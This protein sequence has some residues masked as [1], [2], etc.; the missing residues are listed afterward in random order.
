MQYQ[1]DLTTGE[2]QWQTTIPIEVKK[3]QFINENVETTIIKD[4]YVVV[5]DAFKQ[6]WYVLLYVVSMLAL[7]FHLVHGFS[8]AF[9]TL[10]VN[11]SKYNGLIKFIGIWVFAIII[12]LLF[13]AMPVYFYFIQ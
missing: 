8:S 12:P 2:L 13:A 6:W 10:G 11:H 4:L 9:Q 3:W 1:Q 5:A 7:S